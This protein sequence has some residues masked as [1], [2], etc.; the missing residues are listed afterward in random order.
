MMLNR[1]DR[2]CSNGGDGSGRDEE[3]LESG[4]RFL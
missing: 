4:S 2:W 3:R 1:G